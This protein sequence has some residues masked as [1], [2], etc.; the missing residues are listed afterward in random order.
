MLELKTYAGPWD[1]EICE[2]PLP[3]INDEFTVCSFCQYPY[4]PALLTER[5]NPRFEFYI[6]R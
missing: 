4:V 5:F 6:R 2:T 3:Y 1:C